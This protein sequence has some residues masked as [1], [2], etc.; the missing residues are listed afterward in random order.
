MK[1]SFKELIAFIILCVTL[2]VIFA[3]LNSHFDWGVNPITS[4]M[5][6][7]L[8]AKY[9]LLEEKFE[10]LKKKLQRRSAND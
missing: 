3:V 10:R 4:G 7:G 8:S 6:V 5:I 9:I 1:S 2:S